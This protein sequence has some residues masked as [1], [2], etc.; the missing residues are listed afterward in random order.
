MNAG[1]SGAVLKRERVRDHILELIESL[2]P[3]DAIPSERSLC[4][5]LHVS[6]PTLRA[7]VDELVAAGLLVREHG[8]GMFVAPEKITQEL[9]SD[10]QAMAVPQASGAWTSRLLEFTTIAAGARVGRKLHLSPAA[11]IVYVARLRLVDGA[12]MAIEH[13][14]IPA[15]LVPALTAQE[16][17]AGDLYDHLQHRHGI[18]VSEA[19][20][21]I[22]PTVV[23]QAEAKI[24]GV[25]HLSPAL[26]FERL[27]SDTDGR[28]VEYVHSIYRGDR[29]RIVTRLT[30]GLSAG[31]GQPAPTGSLPGIPPGVL[32]QREP[33]VLTAQGD[34]HADR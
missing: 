26:L 31:Q 2:S 12:P 20:Q 28:A 3:G 19:V 30:L 9:V 27:T 23:S 7:A 5:A 14:H 8:R 21:T 33:V 22:E 16:L 13:L 29:Y 11:D 25:P 34:V 10:Q 17:E 32:P 4:A 1:G 18:E 6:R 24:L 15:D